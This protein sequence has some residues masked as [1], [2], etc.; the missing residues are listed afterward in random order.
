MGIFLAHTLGDVI[1]VL[2]AQALERGEAQLVLLAEDCD[3]GMPS[4]SAL[5]ET[6][7][8]QSRMKLS[9]MKLRTHAFKITYF[10]LIPKA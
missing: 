7:A 3:E 1:G 4:I 9:R 5:G 8:K 6:P 2:F 10:K